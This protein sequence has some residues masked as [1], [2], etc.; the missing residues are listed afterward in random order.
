MLFIAS[1]GVSSSLSAKPVPGR[2]LRKFIGTKVG[3]S[4]RS[5]KASSSLCSSDSPIPKIPPQHNSIPCSLT[6]YAVLT[7]SSYVWVVQIL[8]KKL[9]EVSRLW[10]E[11]L[12]PALERS[13]ACSSVSIPREHPILRLV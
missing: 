11:R 6:K 12:T 9:R 5:S 8:G 7:R 2:G 4:S 3:L 13:R 1:I 10:L